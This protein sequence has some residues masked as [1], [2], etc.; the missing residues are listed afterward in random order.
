MPRSKVSIVRTPKSPSGKEIEGAIRQAID[1]IGG[2]DDTISRKDLVLINPTLVA[3]PTDPQ[4]AVITSPEVTRAVADI[5]QDFGSRPIIAE[6]SAVGVDTEK[7]ITNS[8]Y[9]E[10]RTED[11]EVIDL[12]STTKVTVGI[13]GGEILKEME[14]FELVT[15]ADVIISLPKMKTHDQTELTCSLKKLKGLVTDEQKRRMHRTGVFKGVVDINMLFKPRLSIVDAILCQEGLGPIFGRPVEMNLIVAGKDLV[16]V[17]SICGQIMGYKPEEVLITKFAAERGLGVMDN[18]MIELA[19]ESLENV[20]RRFMRSVEDDPVE[21][22]GFSLLF[23][24]VT[25]TGCRNTVMSAL[26]DMRNAGQ[27]KYLPGVTVI[28]GDPDIPKAIP[29][30]EIVAVGQCVPGDKR[31]RRFVR[32]CPPNNA[33]VVNAIIGG[34]EK[35]R[36]MYAE[37][38]LEETE[39]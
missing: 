14:T 13:E 16:A 20:R 18:E 11:Y 26:V 29:S 6:S 5:V 7:V 21:V 3:P 19:G 30:D 23:G 12:K 32:G 39:E 17:D 2:L 4:S 15:R 22:D 10:L 27:L 38:S 24:G 35:V 34:R 37:K 1:L 25:C 28:T 31:G 33:Y 36:R 9:G 8:G